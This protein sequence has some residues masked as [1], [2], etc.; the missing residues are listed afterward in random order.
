MTDLSD[1]PIPGVMESLSNDM[2]YGLKPTAP[3]SR[4]CRSSIPSLSSS[5]FQVSSTM[6][7][8]I[9]SGGHNRNIFIDPT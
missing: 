7:F 5:S 6:I 2:L 9:P 3:K 4:A 8:E 1:L